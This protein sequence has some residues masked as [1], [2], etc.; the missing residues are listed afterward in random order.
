[1]TNEILNDATPQGND[2]IESMANIKSSEEIDFS[3]RKNEIEALKLDIEKAQL[4]A[5]LARAKAKASTAGTV[6]DPDARIKDAHTQTVLDTYFDLRVTHPEFIADS[7]RDQAIL[8]NID[9]GMK[10]EDG[11]RYSN[12]QD[13]ASKHIDNTVGGIDRKLDILDKHSPKD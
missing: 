9:G 7:Y 10:I 13:A 4:E 1:M 12:Y 8:D 11:N 3:Q 5:E 2:W 6:L